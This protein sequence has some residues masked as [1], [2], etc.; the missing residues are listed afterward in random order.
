ML[1]GLTLQETTPSQEG[2]VMGKLNETIGLISQLTEKVRGLEQQ[3]ETQRSGCGARRE[4]KTTVPLVV[5]V[6]LA[7]LCNMG[8]LEVPPRVSN[9]CA[10]TF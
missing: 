2:D 10:F 1:Y 3:L 5:R 6:S 8:D 9:A 7:L 4:Q